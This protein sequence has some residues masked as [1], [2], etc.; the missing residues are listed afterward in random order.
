MDV[1]AKLFEDRLEWRL[2][3]RENSLLKFVCRV[4]NNDYSE[5]STVAGQEPMTARDVVISFQ[6]P[7]YAAR[8]L[9]DVGVAA[10]R[11]VQKR[12]CPQLF[13]E[14]SVSGFVNDRSL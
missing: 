1:F 3:G 10:Q 13:V 4:C 6:R 12:S 2:A 7:Q 9:G 14:C 5:V 11:S 8:D